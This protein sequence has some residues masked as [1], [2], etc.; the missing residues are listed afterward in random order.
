MSAPPLTL[1][2]CSHRKNWEE[3]G[4]T[5]K[6]HPQELVFGNFCFYFIGQNCVTWLLVCL[7]S[8]WEIIFSVGHI[9]I[10][11]KSAI[12]EW[13]QQNGN[14]I[15]N[16]QIDQQILVL[17][18]RLCVSGTHQLLLFLTAF[19]W[20]YKEKYYIENKMFWTSTSTILPNT[21]AADFIRFICRC[22][23]HQKCILLCLRH[24]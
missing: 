2:P 22:W 6:D 8:C 21:V 1:C 9:V 11:N 14:C 7:G 23:E 17:K 13:K 16:K 12:C 3:N 20:E 24:W 4:P 18:T 19:V 10:P 5:F 15:S